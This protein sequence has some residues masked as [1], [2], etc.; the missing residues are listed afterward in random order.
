MTIEHYE[1]AKKIGL[2]TYRRAVDKGEYP[3][4]P[5]LDDMLKGMPVLYEQALGLVDVPL[6]RIVGTKTSSRQN[7]F[8]RDFMPILDEDTEFAMKWGRLFDIQ[9]QEGLRDPIICYE[10]MNR[11]YVLEGNKRVSV[12]KALHAVTYRGEVTRLIPMKDDTREN[13]IYFEFL[14]FYEATS[15]NMIWF[16]GLGRFERLVEVCGK[17]WKERWTQGESNQ[18]KTLYYRFRSAYKELGGDRIALTTGDAF[19][20]Y[21][22]VFNLSQTMDQSYRTMRDDLIKIW[23]EFQASSRQD[24]INLL[25]AP[26]DKQWINTISSW[27][28]KMEQ[29]LHI[30]FIYDRQPTESS[31]I[32]QHDMGRLDLEAHFRGKIA[33]K[34]YLWNGERDHADLV[35]EQA[36]ADGNK[37]IFTTSSTLLAPSVKAAVSHPEVKILN[38]SI[39]NS[40]NAVRSYHCRMYEGKFIMGLIAGALASGDVIGYVADYPIY[41]M[42]ANINAFALGAKMVNPS[43]KVYLHWSKLA[44]PSLNPEFPKEISYISDEDMI[45]PDDHSM[46]FGFYHLKEGKVENVAA[47]LCNWGK[48][49]GKIIESILDKSWS[50]VHGGSYNYWWGF[51]AGVIDVLFSSG[52]PKPTKRLTEVLIEAMARDEFQPFDGELFDQQGKRRTDESSKMEPMA[53]INMDWLLDNV[54]GFIP[55]ED[56]LVPEARLLVSMQGVK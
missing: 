48:F 54:V 28:P 24:A 15:L 7:A 10:F 27:F 31:W 56:Q 50:N 30:A 17:R 19:L 5:A 1:A 25:L 43:M 44:D 11:F 4:L 55:S 3:F 2:Q 38:C 29:T 35:I 6:N 36:I 33:T 8:A 45:T 32:Y 52:L 14:D 40:Y 41:G 51:S 18:L 13:R 23:S 26:T 39:N 9:L 34:A 53:I 21:L 49:Y 16:S 46:A 37:L 42:I 12:M 47:P 20:I 22:D